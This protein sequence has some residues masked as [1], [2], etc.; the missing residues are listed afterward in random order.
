[1]ESSHCQIAKSMKIN[2]VGVQ[3]LL[4]H[5]WENKV[6]CKEE[7]SEV[8][9]AGSPQAEQNMGTLTIDQTHEAGTMKSLPRWN[10][11]ATS[12]AAAV[13][14]QR[15]ALSRWPLLWELGRALFCSLRKFKD[16]RLYTNP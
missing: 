7:S 10:F 12:R 3:A 6:D 8:M 5:L 16:L 2:Q 13:S 1:L 15:Q 4:F 11:L 9:Y 14:G